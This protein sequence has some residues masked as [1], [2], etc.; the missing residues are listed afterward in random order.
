MLRHKHLYEYLL[1]ALWGIYLEVELLGGMIIFNFLRNLHSVSF[2]F[3]VK[4]F[5]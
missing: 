4:N 3:K 2:N 5:N 1:S